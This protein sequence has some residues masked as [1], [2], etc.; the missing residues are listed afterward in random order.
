MNDESLFEEA[1]Y[2]WLLLNGVELIVDESKRFSSKINNPIT[3][4]VD[5]TKLKSGIKSRD[6]QI[7][8]AAREAENEEWVKKYGEALGLLRQH[9]PEGSATQRA[10]EQVVSDHQNR[11][12]TLK[13]NKQ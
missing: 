1:F 4:I 8:L 3:A 11:I 2:N 6:Q 5:M 9:H 10:L 12:V 7:A 13:E